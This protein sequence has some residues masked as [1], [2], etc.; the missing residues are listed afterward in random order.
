MLLNADFSLQKMNRTL[1]RYH[2]EIA[3]LPL[4]EAEQKFREVF[5]LSAF[6]DQPQ[7]TLIPLRRPATEPSNI[8]IS[9][10]F[11]E[12]IRL[13]R[14]DGTHLLAH[15]YLV[16]LKKSKAW[17]PGVHE[18]SNGS[19]L[20]AEMEAVR[21]FSER[22]ENSLRLNRHG[23][24]VFGELFAYLPGEKK[25]IRSG[26]LPCR[27]KVPARRYEF[28]E[29]DNYALKILLEIEYKIADYIG[30]AVQTF[31]GSYHIDNVRLRYLQLIL[32]LELCFSK[33][34]EAST[35]TICRYASILLARDKSQFLLLYDE[36]RALCLLRNDIMH[37]HPPEAPFNSMYEEQL[38]TKT[39]RLEELTRDVLKKMIKINS[40][41]KEN[42][43]NELKYKR[44][45]N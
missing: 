19:F 24:I 12:R 43:I 40:P 11:Y 17:D 26:I 8:Y 39:E 14:T 22:L 21:Q 45:S 7:D 9:R 18:Q 1:L 42:L 25:L 2:F 29:K 28:A 30:L 35:D 5:G 6:D 34:S 4:D 20:V 36:I 38:N 15:G 13:E 27:A 31:H 37:G 44:L 23:F 3:V 41:Q 33:S 16:C 10:E 32:A